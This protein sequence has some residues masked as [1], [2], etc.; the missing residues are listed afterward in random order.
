MSRSVS[1]LTIPARNEEAEEG[2]V[3]SVSGSSAGASSMGEARPAAKKDEKAS[4][5]CCTSPRSVSL[6]Q[7]VC[8]CV[9]KVHLPQ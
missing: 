5:R 9:C 3:L 7:S 2:A 1:G 6:I 8:A 4:L